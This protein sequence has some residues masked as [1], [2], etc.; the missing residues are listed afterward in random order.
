MREKYPAPKFGFDPDAGSQIQKVVEDPWTLMLGVV[1]AKESQTALWQTIN[2]MN[3]I[4]KMY[5][6]LVKQKF[7]AQSKSIRSRY[8]VKQLFR[9]YEAVCEE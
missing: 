6:Q 2:K 7:M 1:A 8:E 3:D 5:N 9:S 4:K